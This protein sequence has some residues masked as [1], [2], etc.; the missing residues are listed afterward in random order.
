[1]ESIINNFLR[2]DDRF[3]E[4]SHIAALVFEA[5]ELWNNNR[6]IVNYTNGKGNIDYASLSTLRSKNW[7]LRH[8]RHEESDAWPLNQK[9]LT[10]IHDTDE[11]VLEKIIKNL[12]ENNEVW[13]FYLRLNENIMLAE[14]NHHMSQRIISYKLE[15]EAKVSP[16]LRNLIV[17]DDKG[18]EDS[19]M[20]SLKVSANKRTIKLNEDLMDNLLTKNNVGI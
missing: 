3:N 12:E 18:E 4:L 16:Y 10:S 8:L 17:F 15:M 11:G 9:V 1:M 5:T 14:L 13:A 20:L 7:K 2:D 19:T 6:R